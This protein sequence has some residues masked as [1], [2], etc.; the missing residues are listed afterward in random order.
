MLVIKK[1]ATIP[2]EDE[3]TIPVSFASVLGFVALSIM[4]VQ[5]TFQ[6]DKGDVVNLVDSLEGTSY[7]SVVILK[8]GEDIDEKRANV[9][10]VTIDGVTSKWGK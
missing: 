6:V 8:D 10:Y 1:N 5:I 9:K 7:T 2:S 4:V 3:L